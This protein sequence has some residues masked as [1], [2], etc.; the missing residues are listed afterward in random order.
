M[1]HHIRDEF[2]TA[3]SHPSAEDTKKVLSLPAFEPLR[4][5]QHDDLLFATCLGVWAWER[6]IEKI[7]YLRFPGEVLTDAPVNVIGG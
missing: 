2:R 4:D 7:E 5:G 6:A 3:R 1:C